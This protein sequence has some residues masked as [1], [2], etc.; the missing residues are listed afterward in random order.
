MQKQ[1]IHREAAEQKD[2]MRPVRE[3][4]LDSLRENIKD[5]KTTVSE[6]HAQLRERDQLLRA[7]DARIHELLTSTS[8]RFGAP[9]RFAGR[10][11]RYA[12][13]KLLRPIYNFVRRN[14]GILRAVAPKPKPRGGPYEPASIVRNQAGHYSLSQDAG[15]YTYIEPQRPSDIDARLAALGSAVSFTIVVP[16]YN[17]ATILLDALIASVQAQ[18]YPHW[19]LVLADD[20]STAPATRH[21]LDQI[22]HPKIKLLRLESNQGIA[23]ATNAAIAVADGDFIVFADHDDE[24]TVDCLYELALCVDRDQ[25]D[26]AYSDEDKLD[27]QGGYAQPHFKPDW[28]PDTMMSTMFTGHVSCVR[29]SLLDRV[30]PL[31]TEVNGCQDWD[32]VL[33]ISEQTDR[34]SHVPRVLYH[35]RIIPASVASDI[36]AKPYVLEA[37]RRVRAEALLRR[38]LKGTVEPVDE[39]PGYF[40]VNYH[41]RG[42]PRISIIIPTRDGGNVLRCCVESILKVSSYRNFEI[43]ILDNG[44]VSNETVA[45]LR[46]LS[47]LEN[48]R[49]IRHDKPFNFSELN[50]VGAQNAT[51]ELLLFLNDDTEVIAAD[52]LERMGGYAQLPHVGAVGAKLVYPGRSSIQ[53]AGVVNLAIGPAHAF[54]GAKADTPGYF[55]RNLLEY[56]WL[57]VT[58]ACLM[59][60][61][62]KFNAMDGFDESFPIAYNDI[63]LCIRAARKGLFNVVCQAVTLVHHESVTRGL[64]AAEPAMAKRLRGEL[65][66]LYEIHPDYYEF[67]P[68]HNPNLDSKSPDFEVSV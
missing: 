63:D 24:L 55:M 33:R 57:A 12:K 56:N 54:V 36:A 8:W 61:A 48:L 37:S 18:W 31:R 44:S 42:S 7:S 25:P 28:S 15:K 59:I 5:L 23:G 38:K 16:V 49:V 27:E 58:G 45:Y 10:L 43:V 47:G 53:H 50:N 65:R 21:A 68:F 66:R 35:W 67:D 46:E 4:E 6:L 60:E 29:R 14:P 32:L 2:L 22:D 34:I 20:A 40:R 13:R 11:A 52:W 17:T 51:G 64:D 41:L 1:P 3:A 9:L 39:V 19:R 62:Q 26:F 30:G